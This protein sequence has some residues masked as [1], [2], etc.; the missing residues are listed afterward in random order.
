[1][2]LG[3]LTIFAYGMC[4]RSLWVSP[5]RHWDSALSLVLHGVLIA[6]LAAIGWEVLVC[7]LLLPFTVAC[8]LGAYLFYAQHNFPGVM[9]RDR[10]DWNY[11]TAALESSSYIKMNTIMSWFT[12]NIGYHHVH[13]LNSRIPFYRL[14]EAMGALSEL[15]SPHTTTLRPRDVAGCLRLKLW[16]TS[17]QQMVGFHGD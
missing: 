10:E 1:M 3:Y 12:G 9:L 11:V 6:A 7:S 15:Q 4:L 17:K 16:D 8:G 14:P 5:R 2:V 13:H